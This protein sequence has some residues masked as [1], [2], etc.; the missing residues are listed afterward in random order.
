[1][2]ASH[3]RNDL[4]S[5]NRWKAGTHAVLIET[6]GEGGWFIAAPSHGPVHPSGR[7]YDL[8]SGGVATIATITPE[9]KED[10]WAL[11][12]SFDE[13][14]VPLPHRPAGGRSPLGTKRPG[15][16]YNAAMTWSDVLAPH[17]WTSEPASD[18][19]IHWRKPGKITGLSATEGYAGSDLL[20]VFS[21]ATVL[22]A[23]RSFDKFGAYA[24]LDH[25]GDFQAAAAAATQL[26]GLSTR[27][28][29]DL[30]RSDV[31][32]EHHSE[33]F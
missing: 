20:Y 6:R 2:S 23:E 33:S 19:T 25:N 27:H 18:G 1:M 8:F 11:A 5:P 17:G 21:T 7:S 9:E 4:L 32:A 14:P 3:L 12:R 13:T 29:T 15:D 16:A 10:L 22:E 31:F 30:G 26:L 28:L 24:Y